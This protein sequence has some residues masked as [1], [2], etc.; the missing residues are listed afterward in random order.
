MKVLT[1]SEKS[2][3]ITVLFG[4]FRIIS[5]WGFKTLSSNFHRTIADVTSTKNDFDFDRKMEFD[6]MMA[7]AEE[8]SNGRSISE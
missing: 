2:F 5:Y 8:H 3:V 7:M 4:P 1:H 6:E